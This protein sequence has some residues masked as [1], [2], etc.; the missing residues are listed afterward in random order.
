LSV[1]SIS[2]EPFNF[3]KLGISGTCFHYENKILT[4]FILTEG[5]KQKDV[6]EK[7]IYP[8]TDGKVS[9]DWKAGQDLAAGQN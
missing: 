1:S 7:L 4:Y 9:G 8:E 6:N 2:T 3:S 5:I